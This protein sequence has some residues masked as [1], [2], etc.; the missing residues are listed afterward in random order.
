MRVLRFV[1]AA[2]L[3]AFAVAN[4]VACQVALRAE[5]EDAQCTP[6]GKPCGPGMT[7]KAGRCIQCVPKPE[8]CNFEDDDCDGEVDED[9]DRDQDG[10]TVCGQL[11]S[12]LDCNDDPEKGG[13]NIHPGA[14]ELCNGVDD[15]CDGRVDE[16]PNNC[17]EG[18]QCVAAKAACIRSDDCR[19]FGC[20]AG[21]GCN[22]AT[23]QCSDPD[24]RSNPTLCKV[25]AEKCD[26]KSG[27]C[28]KVTGFGDAC[29]NLATCDGS[30]AVSCVDL[31]AIGISAR[32]PS[33]CSKPC[34]ET[35]GCP[36]DFVCRMGTS[37]MSVCVRAIDLS[38]A[39]GSGVAN[40][41]CVKP[42]ECRSGV[43]TNTFCLDGCCGTTECGSGG[44]CSLKS[45]NRFYCRNAVGTKN[46]G[47]SCNG[48]SE[49]TTGY[50]VG[51]ST[52]GPGRCTK[53]CCSSSD[54]PNGWNCQP[55]HAGPAVVT[56]CEPIP[57]STGTGP[58]RGGAACGA[59]AD[60]R[61]NL[62]QDKTCTDYCCRDTDCAPGAV[63]RLGAAEG[64]GSAM[65]CT[66]L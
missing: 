63:C 60:C 15:N 66:K 16:L 62:C 42:E 25:P 54:C 41:K 34:C 1:G 51:I 50:C 13:A 12:N 58:S 23:G 61:S 20:P 14:P 52:W 57:W 19:Q 22:V 26:D 44:T 55:F 11:G 30:P 39:I 9:F 18:T 35:G 64:G 24:C 8:E 7:C 40:G 28:V 6:S 53:H 33:I 45:D 46:V 3:V 27:R 48:H 43:C 65:K 17:T 38:L 32:A 59:S 56:M 2:A 37:G 31:T 29:D 4:A 47:D 49:C 5:D 10:F 36:G 21:K